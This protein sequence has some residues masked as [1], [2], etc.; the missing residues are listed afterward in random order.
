CFERG[1]GGCGRPTLSRK[2]ASVS[3]G[4]EI[5]SLVHH[6]CNLLTN[7]SQLTVSTCKDSLFAAKIRD[8]E[9]FERHFY[10]YYY[11]YIIIIII[12]ILLLLLLLLII[13]I[14]YSN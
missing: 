11:Y 6:S 5:R 13:I 14:I 10:Y 7:L 1:R 8:M 2:R 9:P 12:L 4:I 3:S